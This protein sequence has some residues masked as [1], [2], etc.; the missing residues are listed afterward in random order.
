M[1]R[2]VDRPSAASPPSCKPVSYIYDDALSYRFLF[3]ND[4]I[5]WEPPDTGVHTVWYYFDTPGLHYV[6]SQ[7]RDRWSRVLGWSDPNVISIKTNFVD[8]W[9]NSMGGHHLGINL[10]L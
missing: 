1:K 7:A 4:T 8:E 6:R 5:A 2:I 3:D 10:T 9:P